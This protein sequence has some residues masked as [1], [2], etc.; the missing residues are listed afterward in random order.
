MLVN[1]AT[2]AALLALAPVQQD[3]G[4]PALTQAT[5]R[6]INRGLTSVLAL[7]DEASPGEWPYEGALRNKGKIPIG[8]R[9]GGT[10]FV[11]ISLAAAPSL[12]QHPERREA[13][14]RGVEFLVAVLDD[15]SM[16]VNIHPGYDMR[17]WGQI[18]AAR[19]LLAARKA[20][21]LA[22]HTLEEFDR[23]ISTY[24]ERIVALEIPRAGGWSYHRPSGRLLPAAPGSYM[25]AEVLGV[26]YEARSQGFPIDDDMIAR[27]LDLLETQRQASGV[28]LYSGTIAVGNTPTVPGSVGRMLA[29]E[30]ILYLSGR[31]STLHVRSALDAFLAHWR[32]LDERRGRTGLHKEPHKIAPFYFLYAHLQ[33][34]RAIELL[35]ETNRPEYRAR[36][37]EL[38]NGAR[39]PETFM[40][41]DRVYKRSAAYGTSAAV[42][43]LLQPVLPPSPGWA[44]PADDN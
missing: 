11:V 42:L 10:G 40:W 4:T 18:E 32:W 17:L 27:S 2:L 1:T 14:E 6:I 16:S 5:Q 26:F 34:A 36:L 29:C 41:N 38:L 25:T 39:D 35:P 33:A 44:P 19:G 8:F 28:F 3:V 31:S 13:L 20:G 30:T 24:I 43:A 21:V 22:S 37:T 12:E 9:V 15:P 7:E 23:V